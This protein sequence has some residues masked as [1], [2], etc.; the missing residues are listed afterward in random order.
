V[1]WAENVQVPEGLPHAYARLVQYPWA[2]QARRSPL[3]WMI[4]GK[5]LDGF[6]N[7][8]V[9]SP[10]L[11]YHSEKSVLDWCH[12]GKRRQYDVDYKGHVMPPPEAVAG[13]AKG[14]DGKAVKVA[15]LSAEDKLTLARWIDIGCPIDRDYDPKQPG[16]RGL[17]WML[18]EGRPTL[19]LAS[20]G[21][22]VNR[23]PLKRLLLGMHDYGSGLDL[24]SLSVR[25]DFAVDGLE[26][27]EDLAAKL[28]ALGDGRWEL[29]LKR[30]I[31]ALARGRLTVSVKDRQGNL[32]R[33]ERTFSVA[34]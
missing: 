14:A 15:P 4:Y 31:A 34:K 24:D 19:T 8:D 5:R 20:P 12:H 7:D 10:P 33:I 23:G 11:D 29:V 17:G 3:I 28:K 1:P 27:G 9:P 25:A 16:R 2:F 13:K 32:S 30:P 21:P 18:D 26:P 6:D 22:G